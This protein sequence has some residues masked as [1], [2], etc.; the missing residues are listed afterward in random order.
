MT[1]RA[2][3]VLTM[4]VK[5]EA[6]DLAACLASVRPFV[7]RIVVVDTGSEDATMAIAKPY[8]DVLERWTG[9]NDDQGHIQNFSMARNHALRLARSRL[10]KPPP[11]GLWLDGDDV[12]DGGEHLAPIL[13]EIRAKTPETPVGKPRVVVTLP[14]DVPPLIYPRERIFP[15]GDAEW[16][17]WVHETLMRTST[18]TPAI[19]GA[20]SDNRVTVHHA[21]SQEKPRERGRNLR[22]LRAQL[23]QNQMLEPRGFYYLGRECLDHRLI[24]EGIRWLEHYTQVSRW[25]EERC[26]ALLRMAEAHLWQTDHAAAEI[27]ALRAVGARPDWAEPRLLLAKVYYHRAMRVGGGAFDGSDLR[28]VATLV[29]EALALPPSKTT[30][31]L[32]R[33]LR[34]E[35]HL[36][37]N[38]ARYHLGDLSGALASAA[39]GLADL[40]DHPQLIE[41]LARYRA[42]Q[43]AAAGDRAGARVHIETAIARLPENPTLIGLLV[44]YAEE[45]T[46]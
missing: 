41:N 45:K 5:N 26:V 42:E 9:C 31:F 2:P 1:P 14:Y 21:P 3:I 7:E 29:P 28:R 39:A 6:H 43:C 17:G 11:F 24:P 44:R 12:L 20:L 46:S 19:L 8:A 30:V 40:P 16:K 18:K 36:C 35:A 23:R 37:L 10:K 27:A 32:D 4:I 22:I 15:L 34:R 38:V 13:A 33:S 25:D